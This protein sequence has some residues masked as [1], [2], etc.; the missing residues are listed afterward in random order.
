[1]SNADSKIIE[2]KQYL[3]G[4]RTKTGGTDNEQDA[5]G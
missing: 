4:N 1:M 3:G 5:F 2:Q